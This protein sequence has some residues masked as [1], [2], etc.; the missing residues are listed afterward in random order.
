MGELRWY[1]R[2][3]DA[4]LAGM[5]E[6]TLEEKGAYNTVLDLI[7][8]TAGNLRDDERFIAGWL[9][10]DVRVWRR[11]RQRL[12]DLQ[13][14]YPHGGCLRNRRADRELDAAQHRYRLAANAGL[15]SAAS[16]GEKRNAINKAK[17]TSVQR[18]PQ[19]TTSTKKDITTTETVPRARKRSAEELG[20]TPSAELTATLV[21]AIRRKGRPT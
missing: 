2:D 12:I 8:S 17:S 10:C 11:I 15:M 16:R 18:T 19:L 1:K 9:R 5:A 21:E 14:L 6:L 3:P 4:A 13:K 20:L 7:Y